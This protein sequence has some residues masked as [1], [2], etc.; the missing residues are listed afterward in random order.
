MPFDGFTHWTS[1]L[2]PQHSRP[3]SRLEKNPEEKWGVLVLSPES[4]TAR[5]ENARVYDKSATAQSVGRYIEADPLG[6]RAG[7][8]IYSYAS[9]NPTERFDPWGLQVYTNH[10]PIDLQGAAQ[11]S[12]AA[13]L[14]VTPGTDPYTNT[15][16]FTVP[17]SANGGV[18]AQVVQIL[19]FD[20]GNSQ[21]M[22]P[23]IRLVR[24]LYFRFPCSYTLFYC[25]YLLRS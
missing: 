8:N 13:Q 14:T 12:V 25:L 6:L 1:D 17:P 5:R 20:G 22:N 10:G 19:S 4:P 11:A 24:F 7:P 9:Q 2:E 15:Q 23:A 3:K 16:T 21:N 18:V